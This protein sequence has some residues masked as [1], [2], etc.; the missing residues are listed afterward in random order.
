MAPSASFCHGNTILPTTAYGS[1]VYGNGSPCLARRSQQQT[2]PNHLQAGRDCTLSFDPCQ[3]L[4]PS[5]SA[6]FPP[7]FLLRAQVDAT[8]SWVA[9]RTS[10]ACQPWRIL[11]SQMTIGWTL[12][13]MMRFWPLAATLPS[14]DD[15]PASF[16][17]RLRRPTRPSMVHQD[18]PIKLHNKGCNI[19][20]TAS[21]SNTSDNRPRSSLIRHWDHPLAC[22]LNW[23]R[24]QQHRPRSARLKRAFRIQIA[25][26]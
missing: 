12:N 24:R 20:P 11:E 19:S 14:L 4:R 1:E 21:T 3:Q 5:S 25:V 26:L 13:T 9:D 16:P 18:H 2:I 6:T 8:I 22:A 10:V 7:S 23:T 17:S 15:D